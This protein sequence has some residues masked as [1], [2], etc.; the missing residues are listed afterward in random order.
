MKKLI[1]LGLI[2]WLIT[3]GCSN[4]GL[5]GPE[6]SWQMVQMQMVEGNKVTNYFS[7]H[8]SVYQTKMWEGN[9]FI[10]VGKYLIDTTTT[11]R[12][13]VGTWSL[14]G[15]IYT[16]D[17]KYHFEPSYEG[18]K[19]KIWLEIK[20]DTLLHIFPVNDLG[21]PNKTRHWVEKYVR[22]D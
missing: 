11:Y 9:N 16:E 18:T 6:G 2:I 17:I 5:K 21:E 19:N 10:F 14:V 12:F 20:N 7:D 22:L 3:A 4:Q 15:N 8:Y 1:V 13:G